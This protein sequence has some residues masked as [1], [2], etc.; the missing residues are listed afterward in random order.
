MLKPFSQ[1]TDFQMTLIIQQWHCKHGKRHQKKKK[2]QPQK[3]PQ[4]K[5]PQ[6]KKQ[7]KTKIPTTKNQTNKQPHPNPKTRDF[8]SSLQKNHY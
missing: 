6:P 7:N 8:F 4:T 5:K 1:N 2:K 3:K